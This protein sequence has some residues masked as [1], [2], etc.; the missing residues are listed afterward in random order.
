MHKAV[1]AHIEAICRRPRFDGESELRFLET[2][3]I[4]CLGPKGELVFYSSEMVFL[5]G[6]FTKHLTLSARFGGA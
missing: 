5:E 2:A 4:T 6:S 1:S 3:V